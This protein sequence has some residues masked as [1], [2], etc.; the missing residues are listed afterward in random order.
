M[1]K[2]KHNFYGKQDCTSGDDGGPCHSPRCWMCE[3]TLAMC[4]V[5]KQA[6]AT[7]TEWCPGPK[8]LDNTQSEQ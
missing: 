8:N 5:C 2:R 6:E 4:K 1:K 3:G 7:L